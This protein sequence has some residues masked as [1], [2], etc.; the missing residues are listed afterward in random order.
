MKRVAVGN[1]TFSLAGLKA[2]ARAFNETTSGRIFAAASTVAIMT[3]LVKVT[4]LAKEKIVAYRFGMGDS[5]DAFYIALVIPTFL[6]GVFGQSFNAA[7]VP[8]YVEL[9]E[10]KGPEAAQRLLS[11]VAVCCVAVLSLV[12]SGALIFRGDIVSLLGSGFGPDKLALGARLVVPLLVLLPVSGLTTVWRA[13]LTV[14]DGFAVSSASP[15]SYPVFIMC[16]ILT[17]PAR[18]GASAL[19]Y[20]T[21]LGT[22]AD[23]TTCGIALWRRG[24]SLWP[25]WHGLDPALKRVLRQYSPMVPGA[26][27][28]SSTAVVDQSMA[29]MLGSGSVA[30]LN[31]ANKLLTPPLA[32]GVYAMS[33]ALL[34]TFSELSARRNW[35]E[36]RRVLS[37]YTWTLLVV[38]VPFA[39]LLV[40]FSQP[41][42]YMLFKGGAFSSTDVRLV[43]NVE[44][45]LALQV[46]F[47]AMALLYVQAI[48]ALKCNQIL[49]GGTVITVLMNASLNLL[50]MRM[51]GLAG[52]ALSTSV[53]YAISCGYLRL[54]LS[55]TLCQ[56]EAER[57]TVSMDLTADYPA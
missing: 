53:V 6:V 35:V 51:L 29:A 33:V 1:M 36:M 13:T 46:P 11:S 32:I 48:S 10:A 37:N 19:V 22:A 18:W 23:L 28:M 21:V 24:I 40:Y 54:M 8:A 26:M 2:K 49:L 39:C 44:A 56:Y 43:A 14:H 9:R 42:V 31:Y 12:G 57:R 15:I 3:V 34:P 47:Y 50:F 45:L 27:L 52:I 30:A 55:R 4:A 16:A 7:L 38:F 25:R 20:G 17:L 41:L 5:L